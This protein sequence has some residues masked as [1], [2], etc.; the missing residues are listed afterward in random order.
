M[1]APAVTHEGQQVAGSQS[2]GSHLAVSHL[3]FVRSLA[4]APER[5]LE[6]IDS[7]RGLVIVRAVSG[8]NEHP[9]LVFKHLCGDSV[10]PASA[11]LRRGLSAQVRAVAK[12]SESPGVRCREQPRPQCR[13]PPRNEGESQYTIVFAGPEDEAPVIGVIE[14]DDWQSQDFYIAAINRR[15][16]KAFALQAGGCP[17]LAVVPP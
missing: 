16:E 2:A 3:V 12:D 7:A 17:R 1:P 9:R 4:H 5:L 10:A 13:V 15:I 11:A 8:E 6:R 14:R